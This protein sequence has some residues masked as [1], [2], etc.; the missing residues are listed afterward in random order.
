MTPEEEQ[1][2]RQH[3]QFL[4]RQADCEVYPAQGG[5]QRQ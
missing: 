4:L 3:I 1:R 5:V 2:Y